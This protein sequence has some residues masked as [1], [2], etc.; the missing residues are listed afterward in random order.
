MFARAKVHIPVGLEKFKGRF[1]ELGTRKKELGTRGDEFPRK[2]REFPTH[3]YDPATN[4]RHFQNHCKKRRTAIPQPERNSY[5][6]SLIVNVLPLPGSLSTVS[7]PLCAST[8]SRDMDRP[9]P[10]PCTFVPGTR[11]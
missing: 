3:F 11:K 9:R 1:F 5:G 10:V 7:V 2:S 8:K 4:F 6:F